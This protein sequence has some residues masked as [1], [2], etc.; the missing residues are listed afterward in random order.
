MGSSHMGSSHMGSEMIN[1]GKL[2]ALVAALQLMSCGGAKKRVTGPGVCFTETKTSLTDS[3]V[4]S[5]WP[6]D[7]FDLLL[8]EF[9][10]YSKIPDKHPRICTKRRLIWPQPRT[11]RVH[12]PRLIPL[13]REAVS[14]KSLVFSPV[15]ENERLVWAIVRR[16]ENGEALG[17]VALTK[18]SALGVT[19]KAIGPLRA[20]GK[21]VTMELKST[22][23][24]KVLLVEGELCKDK[25]KRACPRFVRALLLR[26]S[27]FTPVSLTNKLGDC[28]G[29]AYF[30]LSRRATKALPNSVER[31]YVM[32]STV[33]LSKAGIIVHEQ[34]T[35]HDA[36][37][38]E[39]D[40]PPRLRRSAEIDR[41]IRVVDGRFI[42]ESQSLWHLVQVEKGTVPEM[43][44]ATEGLLPPKGI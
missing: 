26:N 24:G 17:T 41:I 33:T 11:C 13:E 38:T 22:R 12:E 5:F 42:P 3:E 4:R 7:W 1:S 18:F 16:Y 39:P 36:D 35:V 29:P 14:E 44:G 23:G 15:T 10:R 20:P 27:K 31:R 40:D 6:E 25:G 2:I 32:N 34:L 37:T 43:S 9:D 19:V 30:P 21:R 28:Q 8:H